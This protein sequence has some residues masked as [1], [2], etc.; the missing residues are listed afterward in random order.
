MP[1]TLF[2]RE[3]MLRNLPTKRAERLLFFIEIRTAYMMTQSWQAIEILQNHQDHIRQSRDIFQFYQFKSRDESVDIKSS[4]LERYAPHWQSLLPDNPKLKAAIAKLMGDRYPLIYDEVPQIRAALGMDTEAVGS[5]FHSLFD[6]NI[7]SIFK[8]ETPTP[9]KTSYNLALDEDFTKEMLRAIEKRFQWRYLKRGEKLFSQGDIGDELYIITSGNLR[10]VVDEG[11][12]DE[13]IIAERGSGSI[14]GEMSILTQEARSASAY[15]LRDTELI[16]LSR[17]DFEKLMKRHTDIML[18]TTRMVIDRL[19]E[20]MRPRKFAGKITSIALIPL[21]PHIPIDEVGRELT[22]AL[23]RYGD[24]L[25][26][27]L[28]HF[29][30]YLGDDAVFMLESDE[31]DAIIIEWLNE[32][33]VLNRFVVF[34]GDAETTTWTRR[35]IRQADVVIFVADA[36]GDPAQRAFER[37]LIGEELSTIQIATELLLLHKIDARP[38]GTAAWLTGRSVR[39]HHHVVH[40]SQDHYKSLARYLAGRSV[41]IVFAGGGAKCFAHIGV[42]RAIQ[43]AGIPID[44][45]GGTSAGAIVAGYVALG[46]PN[47]DLVRMNRELFL[48]FQDYTLPMT[49]LMRGKRF[50]ERLQH[51]FGTYDI[52]DLWL[53]FF[54]VSTNV[55]AAKT[56]VHHDGALYDAIRASASLPAIFPPKLNAQGDVLVDGAVFNNFPT[57]VMQQFNPNG[58]IIGSDFDVKR[59]ATRKYNFDDGVSGWDLFINKR[60]PL[61][62]EK[63]KAP[64]LLPMMTRLTMISNLRQHQDNI[65]IADI[66]ID[67]DVSEWGLFDVADG[68]A[69]AQRGYETA[70]LQLDMWSRHKNIADFF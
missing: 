70:R 54:C 29:R 20:S 10:L 34:Q 37:T 42:M 63:L 9:E 32:Q 52:A 12:E 16:A 45:V 65:E 2:S 40:P 68:E 53:R 31:D 66:Y 27:N 18:N 28:P 69:I 17:E 43:E 64:R 57:D 1:E 22:Q 8:K 35:C 4:D 36:S 41:G 44:I 49:S 48:G 60:N 23:E 59:V 21:D 25:H 58:L 62:Q 50:S 26:L 56:V 5:A 46:I 15:A 11:T 38:S 33:E 30:N 24:T 39:R 6:A 7:A 3:S 13:R 14:I 55:T 19:R 47:D 51:S 61:A 67:T